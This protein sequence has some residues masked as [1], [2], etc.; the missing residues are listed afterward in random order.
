MRRAQ[1][2][3]TTPRIRSTAWRRAVS[4]ATALL[5]AVA[6]LWPAV[7]PLRYLG[8][9]RAMAQFPF[10]SENAILNPSNQ[11]ML[12]L[13]DEDQTTTITDTGGVLQNSS[14]EVREISL[15]GSLAVS[16]FRAG[17]IAVQSES[18][19]RSTV[20]VNQDLERNR[21]VFMGLVINPF[22]AE[23]HQ[24]MMLVKHQQTDLESTDLTTT[25]NFSTLVPSQQGMLLRI[26]PLDIGYF[27][28][29]ATWR[30]EVEDPGIVLL[31]ERYDFPYAFWSL[32]LNVGPAERPFFN[33]V[34]FHWEIKDVPGNVVDLVDSVADHREYRLMLG[35]A[36]FRY[37]KSAI[38]FSFRPLYRLEE[39]TTEAS[40]GFPITERLGM[41]FSQS[42][43]RTVETFQNGGLPTYS[44]IKHTTNGVSVTYN[45]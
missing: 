31:R 25:N 21:E 18:L 8:A 13:S 42:T 14:S 20:L 6:P 1:P 39:R 27:K 3:S 32:G 24:L 41:R 7:G 28:G 9:G 44:T 34:R 30:L 26:Y 38:N 10:Y 12:S 11:L 15:E 45:F 29:S 23:P 5:L 2:Q 33:V 36:V 22:I 40:V 35:S 37:A 16:I 43:T 19:T 4:F 17:G